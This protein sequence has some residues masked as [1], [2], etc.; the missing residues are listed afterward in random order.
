MKRSHSDFDSDENSPETNKHTRQNPFRSPF[1]LERD[2]MS[3]PCQMIA[4]PQNVQVGDLF[5]VESCNCVAMLLRVDVTTNSATM[6]WCKVRSVT[7]HEEYGVQSNVPIDFLKY[8]CV[9]DRVNHIELQTL[10]RLLCMFFS[11]P[12]DTPTLQ[13]IN[14]LATANRDTA[15]LLQ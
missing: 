13:V 4:L 7:G 15:W 14:Q 5:F 3:P 2:P 11:F 12:L 6:A 1:F 8:K 9:T 10:N